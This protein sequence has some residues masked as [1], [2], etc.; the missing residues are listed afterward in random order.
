MSETSKQGKASK[1][2]APPVEGGN[3]ENIRD[4]LFGSQMRQYERRFQRLEE[5]VA[6]ESAEVRSEVK[7]R[8]DG[9]E[10]FVKQ[11]LKALGDRVTTE[12]GER[13]AAVAELGQ[14]LADLASDARGRTTRLEESFGQ[15]VAELRQSLLEQNKSLSDEIRSVSESLSARM[16]SGFDALRV[17]KV[18]RGELGSLLTEVAVR[19]SEGGEGPEGREP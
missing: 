18:D 4:I 17:D 7:R 10:T 5:L 11:E 9:L 12:R 13:T 16:G 14:R 8:L 6:K 1:A 2:A 3:I 19:L 15:A